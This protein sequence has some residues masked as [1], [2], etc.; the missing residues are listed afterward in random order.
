MKMLD[1]FGI[2][3]KATFVSLSRIVNLLGLLIITIILARYFSKSEFASYDQLWLIF[4]TI[5]PIISFAF[6]SSIYFFGARDNAVEYITNI[7]LTLLT[8][9][10]ILTLS[11]FLLKAEISSLFNNVLFAKNFPYFAPFLLF[12]IPSL[13]LD[14]I[15]VLK[16]EFKK[17]LLVSSITISFYFLTVIFCVLLKKDTSFI[18]AGLSTIAFGRLIYT[19]YMIKSFNEKKSRFK[20][21]I[22]TLSE[23]TSYTIPLMLGHISASL[24]R[25]VDKYI[26]ASNFNTEL[27]ATYTIAAKELPIVPVITS[28][29]IAVVLPEISKLHKVGKNSEIAKLLNDVVKSTSILIIPTFVYLMLFSKEFIL[30]LFS[31]KYIGSVPIFRVYLFF[32]LTRVLVF[33]PVLS[34][35]GRQKVYMFVSLFDLILNVLLGLVF[36]KLFGL[37]GP[38]IAVVTSTYFEAIL[39]LFFISRALNRISLS[40]ILPF[41]F[42]FKIFIFSLVSA[43]ISFFIGKLFEDLILKF[44]LSAISF[45]IIYFLTLRLWSL[46]FK[47]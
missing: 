42:I 43:L 11:L 23:I 3:K 28:S 24:S 25:Q 37:L 27:Y 19:A 40:Q 5:T 12:S 41:N 1:N 36:V 30:V 9:G 18:F 8:A 14:A 38:A 6:T 31:D 46:M 29:F 21:S 47:I 20:F 17:L 35:L 10:A 45:A 22:S 16:S 39:M 15:L 33:S 13:I 32:L 7:F 44:I 26:I 34:S 2:V 4:N